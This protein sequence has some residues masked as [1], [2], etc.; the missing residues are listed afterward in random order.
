MSDARIFLLSALRHVIDGGDITNS[1]LDAA[2][3]EPAAL[4]GAER[5]AWHG[6]SYWADDDDIRAKDPAY[7]P[8]R[9]RQLSDLLSA[10]E[11]ETGKVDV[12]VPKDCGSGKLVLSDDNLK[13]L[14]EWYAGECNSDWEHSFGVKIDTLDNPGWSLKIDLRETRLEQLPFVKT[15]FG[16]PASDLEEWKRLGSWWVAEVKS[17]C[18]EAAGGPLDLS[19]MIRVFRDWVERVR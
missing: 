9:R 18:F 17:G 5:K 2:I 10:L 15:S 1:E 6:L 16:E 14:M 8:S 11:D 4:R 12:L 7:A 13:W 3:L 19:T